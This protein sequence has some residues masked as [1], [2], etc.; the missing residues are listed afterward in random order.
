MLTYPGFD[1]VA[2][3]LGPLKIRWYGLMYLLAFATAW[4]LAR[5]RAKR[6]NSGWTPAQADDLIFYGAMGII[7]GGRIG[8]MLF[9]GGSQILDNPLSILKIWEGGMSFHG[10]LL[11][12][13][14]ALMLFA[15]NS[16]RSFWQIGDFTAPLV[17][18][19]LGFG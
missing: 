13:I 3:S 9:Y 4:W 19:G 12:V 5:L 6:P 7:L 1:P 15:R 17:P 18:L 14:I 2:L 11:G 8:Y 10:G 16:G